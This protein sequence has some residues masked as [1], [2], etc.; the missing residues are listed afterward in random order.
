VILFQLDPAAPSTGPVTT[1][2]VIKQP[3][4]DVTGWALPQLPPLITDILLSLDD[5]Y[6]F[7]SNWLRGEGC[8]WG[9]V[10]RLAGKQL[11][12]RTRER[13]CEVGRLE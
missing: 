6:L 10:G 2:T 12:A 5:K 1:T 7:F 11:F 3:W 13:G 9:G 4:V 8:V